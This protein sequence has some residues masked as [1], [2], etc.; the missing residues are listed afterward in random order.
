[1]YIYIYIID[2]CIYILYICIYIWVC[3]MLAP[4][5]SII[6]NRIS[7]GKAVFGVSGSLRQTQTLGAFHDL[8]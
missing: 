4:R 2:I 8:C 3:L 5:H 6:Q 1:M 7:S